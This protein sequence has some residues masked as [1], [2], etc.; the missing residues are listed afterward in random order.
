MEMAMVAR[1]LNIAALALLIGLGFSADANADEAFAKSRMKAMSDYITAQ[2]T[3]SFAYDANLE[4]VTPDHQKIMLANSGT[5]DLSRPDKIRATR[6][7]GFSSVEM[8][9][10]GKTLTVEHK[11]AKTYAQTDLPGTIDHVIEVLRDKYHKPFP[12]ADLL[13]SDPYDK[14]M[15][16][17]TDTKDLGSGVIGGKAK[18]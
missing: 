2:K 13:L 12:G 10:D 5:A 8:L 7:G 17:V 11:D 4:I 1:I 3:I 9:F 15:P 16:G 6:D 18:E 14:L